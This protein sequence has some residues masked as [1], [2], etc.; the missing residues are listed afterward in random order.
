MPRK[1][2]NRIHICLTDEE[3][4]HVNE[5]AKLSGLSREAYT[6]ILYKNLIPRPCPSTEFLECIQQ[7]RRIGNNMN[8]IAFIANSTGNIDFPNFK[9]CFAELQKEI[10]ILKSIT[11]HLTQ[12]Y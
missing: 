9:N 1:R 5:L 6:R 10:L 3:L 2:N 11:D 12:H 7:L 4:A 8:Q